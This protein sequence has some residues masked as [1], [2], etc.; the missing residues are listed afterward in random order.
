MF[1]LCLCLLTATVAAAERP[2][3]V[4][5]YNLE[6]LFDTVDDP[7]TR[8]EEFLP[9]GSKQWTEERYNIK[10]ENLARVLFDIAAADRIFPVVIGVS[11]IENRTV[12][13]DLV[14]RPKLASAGYSVV[15]YDSPDARGVDVAFLYRPSEFLLEGSHAARTVVEG[16]PNFRTRD[17]LTMWGKIDGEPFYFMVAHWPSRLG[18]RAASEPKRM[19]A[20]RQMRAMADSVLACNPAI[21]VIAMGDF[22]DD[23]DN[24][25]MTE[26]LGAKSRRRDVGPT[27]LYNPFASIFRAGSG[28]LAYDGAW[29]LFDNIVV[30][31]NM[32][33]TGAGFHLVQPP[34]SRYDA[35]I[36]RA[37]YLFQREGAYRGYPLRTYVGDTFQGG[38]SDHLPVIIYFEKTL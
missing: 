8:D 20:A 38:Y 37:A 17:I 15:H 7:A 32:L 9:S 5:F 34:S 1:T 10:L 16:L 2:Y 21:R 29:N 30:S 33:G 35:M 3:K 11:E 24:R 18:G 13:E 36:F 28:T 12:L 27:D 22:N 25:S 14:A 6:N 4:V 23:P 26:E 19:A 31:G